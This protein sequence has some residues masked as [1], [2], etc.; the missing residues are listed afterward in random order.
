MKRKTTGFWISLSGA[1]A[2]VVKIILESFGIT[3][4]V[5]AVN[6]IVTSICGILVVVGVLIPSDQYKIKLPS[7]TQS[8]SQDNKSEDNNTINA[9]C[10]DN[11]NSEKDDI[12]YTNK[13]DVLDKNID[14]IDH[15]DV[16]NIKE[17][18]TQDDL[19]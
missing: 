10:V 4:D 19:K 16:N 8:D 3:F 11:T 9:D 2:L 12:I 15:K 13:C 6:Q 14:F 18:N 5:E 17:N 1:V 7:D